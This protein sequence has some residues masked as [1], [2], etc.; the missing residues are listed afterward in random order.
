M[1]TIIVWLAVS[2]LTAFAAGAWVTRRKREAIDQWS[3]YRGVMH[4][5]E[6][7][8]EPEP[9][10]TAHVVQRLRRSGYQPRTPRP[11]AVA[12]RLT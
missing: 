8:P 10:D 3:R 12:H 6:H 2:A 1:S 4:L 9:L 11:S 7:V 5:R